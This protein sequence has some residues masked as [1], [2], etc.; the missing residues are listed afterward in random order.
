MWCCG[1]VVRVSVCKCASV[2]ACKWMSGWMPV[3]VCVCVCE[4]REGRVLRPG[5]EGQAVRWPG[6]GGQRG[7]ERTACGR[8]A[9]V[10]PGWESSAR[11]PAAP[12]LPVSALRDGRRRVCQ[13]PSRQQQAARGAAGQ[14]HGDVVM[15]R[16]GYR[17]D[18][19]NWGELAL[20]DQSETDQEGMMGWWWVGKH[21]S[22]SRTRE[23][24]SLKERKKVARHWPVAGS[25]SNHG[26]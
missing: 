8:A 12:S 20:S 19:G 4:R 21:F 16:L 5:C 25:G 7:S 15:S 14:R 22:A 2:C 13:A 1:G 11:Q 17:G 3:C 10:A 23:S 24:V 26:G 6:S 9:F 18:W